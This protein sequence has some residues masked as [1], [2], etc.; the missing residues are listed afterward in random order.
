MLPA[1]IYLESRLDFL[2]ASFWASL[3][4][5]LPSEFFII[6]ANGGMSVEITLRLLRLLPDGLDS[7]LEAPCPTLR[8]CLSLPQN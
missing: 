4:D 6:D 8:E 5:K 7:I 2:S 1:G 3:A